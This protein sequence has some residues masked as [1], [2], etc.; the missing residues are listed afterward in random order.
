MYEDLVGR[1]SADEG[2]LVGEFLVGESLVEGED[3][4]E[5]FRIL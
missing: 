2:F 5:V 4:G 1:L 3:C